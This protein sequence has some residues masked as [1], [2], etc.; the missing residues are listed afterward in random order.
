MAG[1][2]LSLSTELPS[3][4]S[5]FRYF[6]TA[7]PLCEDHVR[8]SYASRAHASSTAQLYRMFRHTFI[9]RHAS[10]REAPA[11]GFSSLTAAISDDTIYV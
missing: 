11:A 6:S 3:S 10:L 4:Y 2:A 8:Q 1:V 9:Q 7:T 5:T